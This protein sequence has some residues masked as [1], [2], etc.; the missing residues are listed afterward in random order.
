[1]PDRGQPSPGQQAAPAVHARGQA[2]AVPAQT[3]VDRE[4]ELVA[5]AR[6][7]T[8]FKRLEV[9]HVVL[10][11]RVAWVS[12][13]GSLYAYD[14][15]YWDAEGRYVNWLQA[16][17]FLSMDLRGLAGIYLVAIDLWGAKASAGAAHWQLGFKSL[18]DQVHGATGGDQTLLVLVDFSPASSGSVTV[19]PADGLKSWNWYRTTVRKVT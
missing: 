14:P 6:Q 13:R 9:A 4:T 17:G 19:S 2:P 5:A 12:G 3:V 10:T 16:G 8:A 11:P 15:D 1:M 7:L 18:P